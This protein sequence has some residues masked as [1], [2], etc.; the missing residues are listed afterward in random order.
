MGV[1]C[2]FKSFFG[3]HY[4][5]R[6]QTNLTSDHV[7]TVVLSNIKGDTNLF[8]SDSANVQSSMVAD[9]LAI[10]AKNSWYSNVSNNHHKT[11]RPVWQKLWLT[12]Y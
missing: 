5:E 3:T 10:P 2:K 9:R 8:F 7:L 6:N 11:L 12:P 4:L 1:I